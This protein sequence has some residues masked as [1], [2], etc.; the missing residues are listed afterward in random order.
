L[1][2]DWITL[3]VIVVIAVLGGL[4]LLIWRPDRNI[5]RHLEGGAAPPEA[6]PVTTA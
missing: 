5:E 2:L 1:N 3:F 4:Y 6:P